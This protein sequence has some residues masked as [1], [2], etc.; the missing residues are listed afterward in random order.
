MFTEVSS[1][2]VR[3]V[4]AGLLLLVTNTAPC[5]QLLHPKEPMPSFEVTSVKRWQP[6]DS[7]GSATGNQMIR[8]LVPVGAIPVITDRIDRIGQIELLIG[9]AYGIPFAATDDRVLGGP[10]WIRRESDRYEVL[11]KIEDSHYAALQ[12]TSPAHQQEQVSLMEQ[13]LLADR[14]KLRMHFETREMPRYDLVLAKGG[15]KLA[16][17]GDGTASQLS[18]VRAG[19]GCELNATAVTLA[20]LARS[21]FLRSDKREV[22]DRTGLLGRFDFTLKF[23]S[24]YCG[25]D[26]GRSEDSPDAPDLFSALQEQ[27][28]L[29]LVAANGPAEVIVIDHIERPSEN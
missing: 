7:S 15:S 5:H 29:K 22:V 26:T 11:G 8:K 10:D 16:S 14:F 23:S 12:K 21:P 27:L 17:S 20:E 18:L 13:S 1:R 4:G 19:Q 28:G 2:S 3:I 6:A 9:A 25:A 24:P